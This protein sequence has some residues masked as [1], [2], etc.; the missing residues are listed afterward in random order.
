MPLAAAAGITEYGSSIAS[1]VSG[2]RHSQNHHSRWIGYGR[3]QSITTA[4]VSI[5]AGEDG[6]DTAG[7]VGSSQ[8]TTANKK[9]RDIFLMVLPFPR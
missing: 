3:S 6:P 8:P 1:Q 4:D 9:S 5:L 7:W 2:L